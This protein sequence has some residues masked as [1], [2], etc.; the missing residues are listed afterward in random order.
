[1]KTLRFTNLDNPSG[2]QVHTIIC[3]NA[4]V[5]NIV[6][7]YGGFHAN[8]RIKLTINNVRQKLDHN[9]QLAS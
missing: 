8:D 9:G 6:M 3:D 1:M 5:S 4:S 2:Y 7:W